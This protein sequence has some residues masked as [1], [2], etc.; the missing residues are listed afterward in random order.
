MKKKIAV[1]FV[2]VLLFAFLCSVPASAVVYSSKPDSETDRPE[3][4]TFSISNIAYVEYSLIDYSGNSGS[5]E[6]C[7]DH[8]SGTTSC[9]MVS[10]GSSSYQ[11]ARFRI[12]PACYAFS[13]GTKFT[14]TPFVCLK[15]DVKYKLSIDFLLNEKYLETGVEPF[16][17][18]ASISG[19][20]FDST[21]STVVKRNGVS[22]T[23]SVVFSLADCFVS[24]D[25]V[26]G[27]FPLIDVYLN[28]YGW[29][30]DGNNV[31][32]RITSLKIEHYDSTQASIDED[33]GFSDSDTPDVADKVIGFC[34][35][36]T[37]IWQQ[38]EKF[39]NYLL[40]ESYDFLATLDSYKNFVQDVY[41]LIP[42]YVEYLISFV[43]AFFILRRIVGR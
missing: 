12:T 6:Y 21:V 5:Y 11:K 35:N 14:T 17:L 25:L 18:Y 19:L 30:S 39:K 20:K 10:F 22:C 42:D 37:E 2:F 7:K 15:S 29:Q 27:V 34:N 38:S 32:L 31:S 3:T 36:I 33:Y 41:T 28:V 26:D 13:D 4:G 43:L 1:V 8:S 16:D 9:K 23:A 24:D 40:T